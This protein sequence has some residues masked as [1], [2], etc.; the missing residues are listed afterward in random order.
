[1]T[2]F[3]LPENTPYDTTKQDVQSCARTLAATIGFMSCLVLLYF[4][5]TAPTVLTRWTESGYVYAHI[6]YIGSL[7]ILLLATMLFPDIL[8]RLRQRTIFVWNIAF[9]VCLTL[10]IV[11]HTIVFP[12]TPESPPVVVGAAIS[13]LDIPTNRNTIVFIETLSDNE[14]SRFDIHFVE[15]LKKSWNSYGPNSP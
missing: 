5:F 14:K 13:S 7:F 6:F 11:R 10:T 2:K 3:F 15:K 12:P 9:L 1:M 4:A 8:K